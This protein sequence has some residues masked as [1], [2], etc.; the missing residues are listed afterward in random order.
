MPIV[1]DHDPYEF[2]LHGSM[3]LAPRHQVVNSSK[4]CDLLD[5][6]TASSGQVAQHH[7]R[8]VFPLVILRDTRKPAWRV[9]LI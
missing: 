3:S 7:C 4:S 5:R 6:D 1:T 9:H 8:R 2:Q